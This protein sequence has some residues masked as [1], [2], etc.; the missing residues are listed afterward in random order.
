MGLC[1]RPISLPGRCGVVWL[2]LGFAWVHFPVLPAPPHPNSVGGVSLQPG[3][4]PE[5]QQGSRHPLAFPDRRGERRRGW[6]PAR[7]REEAGW[8]GWGQVAL[9]SHLPSSRAPPRVALQPEQSPTPAPLL[10]MDFSGPNAPRSPA[11]EKRE[12]GVRR[13]GGREWPRLGAPRGLA[14]PTVTLQSH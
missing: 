10:P 13:R 12:R 2:G 4:F 9:C 7:K 3:L 11:P 5:V 14:Y 6:G 1:L 8:V